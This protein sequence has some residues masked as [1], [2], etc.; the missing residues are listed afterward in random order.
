M[1]PKLKDLERDISA[2][3]DEELSEFRRW[4]AEFD[5]RTWDRQLD[6]DVRAGSLDSA[7]RR[8]SRRSSRWSLAAGVNH[9]ASPR[10][11]RCYDALPTR[12]RAVDKNFDLLK[13][14]P[15]ALLVTMSHLPSIGPDL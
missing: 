1:S 13:A 12:I 10:F 3:S 2:L 4:Y 15:S 5:A 14:D 9:H 8:S 11:W 7:C 6:A